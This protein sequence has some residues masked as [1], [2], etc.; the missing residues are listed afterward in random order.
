MIL[1][2]FIIIKNKYIDSI[3]FSLL[4]N[5]VCLFWYSLGT[6]WAY[7]VYMVKL[8]FFIFYYYETK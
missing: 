4:A 5:Q 1:N 3:Y 6:H 8:D 2:E 7:F